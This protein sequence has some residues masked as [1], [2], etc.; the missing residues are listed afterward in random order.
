[1]SNTDNIDNTKLVINAYLVNLHFKII[2]QSSM[3]IIV[4]DIDKEGAFNRLCDNI[5]YCFQNTAVFDPDQ[6]DVHCEPSEKSESLWRILND[7][8]IEYIDR[9]GILKVRAL[10]IVKDNGKDVKNDESMKHIDNKQSVCYE[11]IN[12]DPYPDEW[13][14]WDYK[15]RKVW[16]QSKGRFRNGMYT[17]IYIYLSLHLFTIIVLYKNR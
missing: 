12:D 17:Y 16:L 9:K 14:E 11:N 6:F 13:D 5:K 4:K 3:K 1:M 8:Q 2:C 15:E 7:D 10:N